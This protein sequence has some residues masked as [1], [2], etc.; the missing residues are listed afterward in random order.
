VKNALMRGTLQALYWLWTPPSPQHAARDFDEAWVWCLS[1]VEK[2]GLPLPG[3][4]RELRRLA[5][6]DIAK[7]TP[8]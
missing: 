2:R 1:M 5:D 6:R 4:P 8:P 7:L 3:S